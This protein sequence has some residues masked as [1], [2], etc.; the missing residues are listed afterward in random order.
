MHPR[1]LRLDPKQDE[2]IIGIFFAVVKKKTRGKDGSSPRVK[3]VN[4]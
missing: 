4:R 2:A 1:R 3:G